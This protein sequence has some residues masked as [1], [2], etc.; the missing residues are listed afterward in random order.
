MEI[1]I[2]NK[3]IKTN[4]WDGPAAKPISSNEEK[5]YIQFFSDVNNLNVF[6]DSKKAYDTPLDTRFEHHTCY[7]LRIEWSGRTKEIKVGYPDVPFK[8]PFK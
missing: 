1:D 4:G 7:S 5:R 8:H 6:F 3:T 2:Q